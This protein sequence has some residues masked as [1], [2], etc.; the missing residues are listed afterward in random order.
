MT[1]PPQLCPALLFAPD[2]VALAA[3]RLPNNGPLVSL[4]RITRPLTAAALEE[5]ARLCPERAA[6][7]KRFRDPHDAQRCLIAGWLL[8]RAAVDYAGLAWDAASASHDPRGK[9]EFPALPWVHATATH[10]GP[11]VGCGLHDAPLGLD[12]ES[13]AAC[14]QHGDAG[15]GALLCTEERAAYDQL[16]RDQKQDFLL[17]RWTLKECVLKALGLGFALA[18]DTLELRPAPE[19]EARLFLRSRPGPQTRIPA[20]F[21][22]ASADARD[23]ERGL[24]RLTLCYAARTGRVLD[25]DEPAALSLAEDAVASRI[26]REM[27]VDHVL[28]REKE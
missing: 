20:A 9:P 4:A 19:R 12:V 8:R 28:S 5:L 26:L 10:A 18:P 1:P 3:R 22:Y 17:A 27:L 24:Y 7:A 15:A 21:V 13:L 14:S 25:P 11:W 23:P 2:G 6:L 16:P